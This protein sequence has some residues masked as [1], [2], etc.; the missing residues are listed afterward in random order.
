MSYF[1]KCGCFNSGLESTNEVKGGKLSKDVGQGMMPSFPPWG[2]GD[3]ELPGNGPDAQWRTAVM[4][5]DQSP[6]LQGQPHD[7]ICKNDGSKCYEVSFPTKEM[8]YRCIPWSDKNE[9]VLLS[10]KDA[11]GETVDIESDDCRTIVL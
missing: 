6:A 4:G 9:T 10:C 2:C 3:Y 8:M 5:D 1:A 7:C 11:D